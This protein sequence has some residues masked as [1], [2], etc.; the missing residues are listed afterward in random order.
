M[1][2]YGLPDIESSLFQHIDGKELC[3]LGK[4]GFL[5]LTSPY[6]TEILLSHLTYLRQS[7]TRN[8]LRMG[9][10]RSWESGM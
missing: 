3:K 1:K 8:K 5:R 10:L 9:K 7:K 6:N 2:E 4:E